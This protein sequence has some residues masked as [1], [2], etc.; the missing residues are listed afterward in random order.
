[1]KKIIS[2]AMVLC[3]S[4]TALLC[5]PMSAAAEDI[6]TELPVYDYGTYA[7]VGKNGF[8]TAEEMGYYVFYQGTNTAVDSRGQGMYD[9]TISTGTWQT[10]NYIGCTNPTSVYENGAGAEAYITKANYFAP[11]YHY[12]LGVGF[13]A[14]HTGKVTFTLEYLLQNAL[15]QIYVARDTFG[16]LDGTNYVRYEEKIVGANGGVDSAF[17]TKTITLDVEQGE[18]IYFMMDNTNNGYMSY[19]WLQS[20]EYTQLGLVAP[21]VYDNGEAVWGTASWYDGSYP[22]S[23]EYYYPGVNATADPRPVGWYDMTVKPSGTHMGQYW[24]YDPDGVPGDQWVY[25]RSSGTVLNSANHYLGAL[26]FTAPYTGTITFTYQFYTGNNQGNQDCAL[27]IGGGD[28]KGGWTYGDCANVDKQTVTN[29]INSATTDTVTIDVVAGEKV[30]FMHHTNGNHSY[31]S[32][33]FWLRKAEYTNVNATEAD[34]IGRGLASNDSLQ[35]RFLIKS[36][37]LG[38]ADA[39]FSVNG[40][41]VE[42]ISV[43]QYIDSTGAAGKVVTEADNVYAFTV[44]LSAKQMTDE[45]KISVKSGDVELLPEE[46]QTYTIEDYCKVWIAK[47]A[48]DKTNES[49]AATAKVCASLLLYGRMAQ[50][51]FNY[52]TSKLPELD[53]NAKELIN[54]SIGSN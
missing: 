12:T 36:N 50:L 39:T 37:G 8:N 35:V 4:L 9:A 3:M 10:G 1:M 42:P 45:I 7:E 11:S 27:I 32:L 17:T 21:T 41:A 53:A 52:N 33:N 2:I 19:M 15:H 18:T 29:T 5:V 47:Y 25:T 40:E 26:V 16:A 23:Y 14:P 13:T 49:V 34:V 38:A 30:Y 44:A 22:I 28:L 24:G 54:A 43:E 6:S 48:E 51:Q 31:D 46:D 20:A